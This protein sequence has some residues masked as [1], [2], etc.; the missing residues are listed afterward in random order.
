VWG[1]LITLKLYI[2]LDAL[3]VLLC[4]YFGELYE[5]SILN[6]LNMLL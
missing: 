5:L 2:F 1:N 4:I 3:S 6:R